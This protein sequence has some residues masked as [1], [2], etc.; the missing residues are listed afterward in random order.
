MSH[1]RE[2]IIF[3]G[4]VL[5]TGNVFNFELL[6]IQNLNFM[7]KSS[8]QSMNTKVVGEKKELLKI[9]IKAS[10]RTSIL[11]SRRWILPDQ[12]GTALLCFEYAIFSERGPGGRSPIKILIQALINNFGV[13]ATIQKQ[14]S[15]YRLYIR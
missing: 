5:G 14:R 3:V 13:H 1:P 2:Y 15:R 10:K 12:K 7:M 4:V 6:A 8:I 11:V 9:F